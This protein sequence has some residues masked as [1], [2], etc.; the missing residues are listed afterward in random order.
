MPNLHAVKDPYMIVR[1]KSCMPRPC[2]V[3]P[4]CL[5]AVGLASEEKQAEVRAATTAAEMWKAIGRDSWVVVPIASTSRPG[6]CS[7]I[8]PIAITRHTSKAMSLP[9]VKTQPLWASLPE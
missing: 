7:S 6:Q 5:L 4:S 9:Y 3:S 2:V 8:G 1:K